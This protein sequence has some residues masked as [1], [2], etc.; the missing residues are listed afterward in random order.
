M[1][2]KIRALSRKTKITVISGITAVLFIAVFLVVQNGGGIPAMRIEPQDYEEKIVAVGSLELAQE[3]SLTAEV[4]G[5][6]QSITAAEGETVSSGALLIELAH[7][8]REFQLQ[9]VQADYLNAAA[10]Y[11]Q[12]TGYQYEAAKQALAKAESEKTQTEKAYRDALNLYN[13]GAVSQS[14]MAERRTEYESALSQWNTA[15][16]NVQALAEGGALRN[17][18]AAK[19]Q[20]ASAAYE[21]AQA[22]HAKY[23]ILVPWDSVVLK[24]YVQQQDY[25][26]AGTV[27]ADIGQEGAYR[28]AVDLDEK[29]FPYVSVGQKAAVFLG[30]DNRTGEAEGE[31]ESIAPSV[32]QNTGTF[33]IRILLPREFAYRASNLTVNV[34]ILLARKEAAIVIPADYLLDETH[35]L[36][37]QNGKARK[38]EIVA[39]EN[40]SA[41]ILVVSGLSAGDV[42]LH[43]DEGIADGDAVKADVR[44]TN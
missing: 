4:S 15:K 19:L 29:Y 35:V 14:E 22:T 25:V 7:E 30:T 13:E 40:L 27:L 5:T 16:L 31:I 44:E 32:S 2:Q 34:E 20:G 39:E 24:L 23:Q 3:T 9:N 26:E 18:S 38:A 1:I 37:Y 10:E 17:A 12:L 8:D 42:I 36:L 11:E 28:V 43:P 33:G 6:V 41:E 21:S